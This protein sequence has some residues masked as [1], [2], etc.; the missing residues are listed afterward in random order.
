VVQD[1]GLVQSFIQPPPAVGEPLVIGFP[2]LFRY[3]KAMRT[4]LNKVKL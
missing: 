2:T 4:F 1:A 3:R